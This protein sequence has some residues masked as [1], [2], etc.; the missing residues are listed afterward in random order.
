MQTVRVVVLLISVDLVAVSEHSQIVLRA[1]DEI[2]DGLGH[3]G[4]IAVN[5]R[6]L[7]DY[8]KCLGWLNRL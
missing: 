2:L 4:N 7:F 6:I 3:F 1:V 5:R 8:Y